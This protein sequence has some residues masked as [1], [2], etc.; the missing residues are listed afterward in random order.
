MSE[1]PVLIYKKI[2]TLWLI[3]IS[4]NPQ[5]N[6]GPQHSTIR[7]SKPLPYKNVIQKQKNMAVSLTSAYITQRIL[8]FVSS[9]KI[10]YDNYVYYNL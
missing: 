2:Q 7:I 3:Y 4:H 1:V 8:I 6:I 10:V 5:S 9:I